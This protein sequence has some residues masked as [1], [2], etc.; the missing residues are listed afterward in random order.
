[1]VVL[2]AVIALIV[3]TVIGVFITRSA[4]K[5]QL[6]QNPPL[7]EDMLRM[8]M[9]Q[10]GRKPSEAQIRQMMQSLRNQAKKANQKDKK[11]K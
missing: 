10:M 1:M 11:K 2:I 7:N 5:K 9:M 3:G 4:V 6:E 8:M